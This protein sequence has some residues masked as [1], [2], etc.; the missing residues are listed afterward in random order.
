MSSAVSAANWWRSLSGSVRSETRSRVHGARA[1]EPGPEPAGQ[2]GEKRLLRNIGLQAGQ[3]IDLG[4]VR[5]R[6]DAVVEVRVIGVWAKGRREPWWLA[7]NR[8]DSL[9]QLVSLYD[10]RMTIEEQKAKKC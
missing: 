10:R 5:P 7:T 2:D 9:G 8:D 6:Q 3:A 1:A 4:W